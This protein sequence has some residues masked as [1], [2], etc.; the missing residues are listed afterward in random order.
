MSIFL[1]KT[2]EEKNK[3]QKKKDEEAYKAASNLLGVFVKP[4]ILMLLWNWLMPG[5]FGL[6]TIGYL[7]AVAL[8]LISRILFASSNE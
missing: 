1:D 5:L 4:V 6:A 7:K 2:R 8:Y 3:R